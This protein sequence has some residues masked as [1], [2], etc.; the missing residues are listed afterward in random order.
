MQNSAYNA[1]NPPVIAIKHNLP[2]IAIIKQEIMAMSDTTNTPK[3][4]AKEAWAALDALPMAEARIQELE[5]QLANA[6]SHE[7]DVI[8]AKERAVQQLATSEVQR[9]VLANRLSEAT[10]TIERMKQDL[11]IIAAQFE[12]E[13]KKGFFAR[14]FG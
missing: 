12:A 7:V 14:L 9:V 10:A 4:T 6:V 11:S 8:N 5:I 1:V 13:M 2:T 3:R